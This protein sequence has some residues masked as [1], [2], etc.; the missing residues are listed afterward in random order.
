MDP[1]RL[2]DGIWRPPWPLVHRE[3]CYASD[4]FPALYEMERKHFWYRGRYRFLSEAVRRHLSERLKKQN[5][6]RIIDIGGGC[7]G[8]VVRLES[9][10]RNKAELA[11]GDSSLV[12]LEFARARVSP[13]TALY[14]LDC[15]HLGWKDRWDVVFLLDVLEHLPDDIG[16][17]REIMLALAKGGLVFVTVPALRAFWTYNDELVGHQRRYCKADLIRVARQS[18]LT[19]RETRYFMFLLS[20]LLLLSRWLSRPRRELSKQEVRAH[21]AHTHRVPPKILN[22]LLGAIFALE[23]PLGHWF[24][25]PWGTSLLGVFEKP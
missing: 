21:L 7:G 8:W 6:L 11:L 12:A 3:E 24:S 15:T 18:G 25:F 2:I 14:H 13:N 10:L 22:S 17:M 19:V 1:Y 9:A 23:T 20:P 4:S 5:R 16:V